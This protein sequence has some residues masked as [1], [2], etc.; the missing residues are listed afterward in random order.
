MRVVEHTVC[1]FFND[2]SKI[3]VVNQ[4]ITGHK[5]ICYLFGSS[6]YHKPHSILKSKSHEF[7]NRNIVLFNGNDT[8][9]AGYFIGTHRYLRTRKALLATFASAELNTMSLKSK[10]SKLVS[11]IQ[12]NNF[13]ERIYVFLKIIFPCLWVLRLSDSNKAG[14]DKVFYYARMTKISIINS[15]SD[16]DN[17]GPLLVSSS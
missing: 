11:Y 14:M 9:M 13:W 7:H 8:R 4:M 17:E 2:V 12:D 5:A 15:S 16:L 3:L 6:I 10:L 1:L